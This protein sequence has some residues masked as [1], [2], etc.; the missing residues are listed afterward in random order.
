MKW[1]IRG[2]WENFIV[3]AL[4]YLVF[5]TSRLLTRFK[6]KKNE[7]RGKERNRRLLTMLPICQC[8]HFEDR[9]TKKWKIGF[10]LELFEHDWVS[11]CERCAEHVCI[12]RFVLN[13]ISSQYTKPLESELMCCRWESICLDDRCECACV[14]PHRRSERKRK[15]KKTNWMMKPSMENK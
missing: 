1:N 4:F 10:E 3:A 8:D 9:R 15:K 14:K 6:N 12:Y 5:R 13:D 7:R 2:S 11:V